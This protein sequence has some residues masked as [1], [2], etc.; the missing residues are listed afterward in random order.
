VWALLVVL[1]ASGRSVVEGGGGVVC[2]F[3][4]RAAGARR[5]RANAMG[6]AAVLSD[7][8]LK[9]ILCGHAPAK[10]PAAS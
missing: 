6:S 4:V 1:G 5:A 2:A 10:A 7:I 3:A 8:Q 9:A